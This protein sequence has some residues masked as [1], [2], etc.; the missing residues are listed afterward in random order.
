MMPCPSVNMSLSEDTAEATRKIVAALVREGVPADRIAAFEQ[1]TAGKGYDDIID[2]TFQGGYATLTDYWRGV[3]WVS[4]GYAC[5]CRA[6][7]GV[8]PEFIT[9]MPSYSDGAY[10]VLR[11]PRCKASFTEHVEG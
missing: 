2:V 6:D 3:V 9:S 7:H 10:N 5:R 8:Q 11:C 1:A 4:R